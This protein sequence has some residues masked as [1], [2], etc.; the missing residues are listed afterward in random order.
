M[1]TATHWTEH[2]VPNGGAGERTEGAEG[3][4]NT[5]GR[6]AIATNQNP[7]NSQE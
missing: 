7:W 6:I 2:V 5:I 1:L 4:R 3:V